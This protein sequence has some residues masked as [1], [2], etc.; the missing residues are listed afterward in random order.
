MVNLSPAGWP[1]PA[2]PA[3]GP[4]PG[5][6]MQARI[7]DWPGKAFRPVRKAEHLLSQAEGWWDPN[8]SGF[9][10]GDRWLRNL[11]SGGQA[12]DLRLGSSVVPNSNDPKWLPA[13]DRGYVYCP[14][15]YNYLSVPDEVALDLSHD[16]T[17]ICEVGPDDWTFPSDSC[18]VGK[19]HGSTA[20]LRAWLFQL[21]PYSTGRLEF[22]RVTTAGDVITYG[23]SASPGFTDGD[24]RFVK[25]DFDLDNGSGQSQVTYSKSTDGVTYSQVGTVI[26]NANTTPTRDT[27]TAVT[28]GAMSDGVFPMVGKVFRA[29]VK[30][31][32]DGATV[33][34][35]DCDQISSAAATQ[36]T[37]TTGQTVTINRQSTPGRRT[38]VIP[39]ARFRSRG[40]L[41]FGA[42]DYLEIPAEQVAQHAL[43]NFNQGDA[44]TVVAVSR[45]WTT[46][47]NNARL[48][49]KWPAAGAGWTLSQASTPTTMAYITDGTRNTQVFGTAITSGEL[50]VQSMARGGR[51]LRVALNTVAPALGA[52]ASGSLGNQQVVRVGRDSGSSTNYV[53]MEF[54]A[55]AIFRRALSASELKTIS[56]YYTT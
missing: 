52:D 40:M 6:L 16:M 4:P 20:S 49:S 38:I 48:V 25:M 3:W 12:L 13:A 43:L 44:F 9:R 15:N 21:A 34:D 31:G 30:N 22:Y 51:T 7:S 26:T 19:W 11:G 1:E 2:A 27:T 55:A 33:L 5:N 39:A 56:D 45:R 46:I 28:V 23:S 8:A 53:D 42:D 18:L 54:A 36:F 14:G 10:D 24:V 35:I 29:L 50:A 32:I 37:A 17:I 47:T 41:A